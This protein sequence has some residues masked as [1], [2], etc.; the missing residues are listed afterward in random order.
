MTVLCDRDL[1]E[2][3][4]NGAIDPFDGFALQ[5]AS[6][7]LKLG[8]KFMVMNS[9]AHECIDI[10]NVPEDLMEEKYIGG[11][12]FI[13]LHP[14]EFM[15]A[16]TKEIINVPLDMLGRMEGKSSLGRIGLIVHATAGFFD[17]GWHGRGTL[18]LFN[19]ANIPIR[20]RPGRFICQF[21]FQ[22]LTGRVEKPYDGKYQGDMGVA[23]SRLSMGYSDREGRINTYMRQVGCTREHAEKIVDSPLNR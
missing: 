2:I 7:D 4:L 13:V 10:D 8:N 17:P 23:G 16:E 12:G 6:I 9:Y 14:Q 11:D 15:L 19:C 5:P 20:L 3:A 22:M 1:R 18:E 21:S